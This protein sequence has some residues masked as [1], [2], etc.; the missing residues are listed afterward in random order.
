MIN[1]EETVDVKVGIIIIMR[2]KTLEEFALCTTGRL[3]VCELS[4]GDVWAE[5]G[6][7]SE[8]ERRAHEVRALL[9]KL[10]SAGICFG[11]LQRF[12]CTDEDAV[13]YQVERMKKVCRLARL[14][15][16]TDVIRTEGGQPKERVPEEQWAEAIAG[17]LSKLKIS[18]DRRST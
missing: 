17:C 7:R 15:L 1:E 16:G 2:R 6:V 3:Q 13:R 9:E 12:R 18:G 8:A 10:R 5:G 14:F 4:I 11:R